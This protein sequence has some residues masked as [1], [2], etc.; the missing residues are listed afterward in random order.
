MILKKLKINKVEL[1]N[2]IVISPMCQ[3]SAVNGSPSSWHYKHLQNLSSTGAGM[4]I[5]ES[6]AVNKEAKITELDLCLFNNSHEKKLKEMILHLKKNNNIKYGIQLAHAGRKGSSHVPWVK[7]NFPLPNKRSWK[8]YS[9]SPIPRDKNW[10]TP[11]EMSKKQITNLIKSFKDSA[12]RANRA[13][14]DCLEIHMAH[15]YL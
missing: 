11:I 4:V 8:T 12:L 1:L 3:Y 7:K 15:G 5:L 6:T 10:P 14:F 9:A 2:R 13:G